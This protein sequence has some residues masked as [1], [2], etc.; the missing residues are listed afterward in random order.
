M[1][2]YNPHDDKNWCHVLSVILRDIWAVVRRDVQGIHRAGMPVGV[3]VHCFCC[4]CGTKFISIG[5]T[6]VYCTS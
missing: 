1:C 6:Y 4:P 3:V 5:V 2:K